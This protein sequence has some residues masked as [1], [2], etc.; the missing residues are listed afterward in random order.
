V[1]GPQGEEGVDVDE[2]RKSGRFGRGNSLSGQTQRLTFSDDG[3][4]QVEQASPR[5]APSIR[6]SG[7]A[8][9]HMHVFVYDRAGPSPNWQLKASP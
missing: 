1:F 6:P 9:H 3:A 8:M 7:R 5:T 2:L 4:V